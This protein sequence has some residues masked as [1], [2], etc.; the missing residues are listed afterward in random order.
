MK[1]VKNEAGIAMKTNNVFAGLIKIIKKYRNDSIADIQNDIKQGN[2][3]YSCSF[4]G[5][6]KKFK[7]LLLLYKE[8]TEA[9][10]DV[11]LYDEG[12]KSTLEEF[13]NWME[14]ISDTDAYLDYLD[15]FDEE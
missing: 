15:Q 7:Q 6:H 9:G 8:L 10:F 5:E 14:S 4:S 3:V 11:E 2:Y 12:E 1:V 13:E